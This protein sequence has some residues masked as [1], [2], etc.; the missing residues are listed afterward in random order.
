ML[1][2]LREFSHNHIVNDPALFHPEK[3]PSEVFKL[4][5]EKSLLGAPD[6][7]TIFKG[8]TIIASETGSLGFATVWAEQSLIPLALGKWANFPRE[9]KN[10]VKTG[11]TNVVLAISESKVGA[12]P[13]HLT[14]TAIKVDHGWKIN[15]EKTN[16]T[17]GPIASHVT[18]LAITNISKTIKEYSIFLVDVDT[19]GISVVKQAQFD[20][21]RPAQHCGFRMDNLIVPENALIGSAGKGYEEIA[22]PFRNLEDA[23]MIGAITGVLAKTSKMIALNVKSSLNDEISSFLGILAGLGTAMQALHVPIIEALENWNTETEF[24]GLHL[25]AFRDL[26]HRYIEILRKIET[27]ADEEIERILFDVEKLLDIGRSA[28]QINK[29]KLGR[30]YFFTENNFLNGKSKHGRN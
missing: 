8:S 5:G 2:K 28:H 14:T 17:N 19:K 3:F 9:L 20:F 13:K 12:H 21:L 7:Q 6:L 29:V 11:T 1:N 26:A 24:V 25:I 18:V 23:V 15:G 30:S 4:M 10:G 16:I 22:K 27:S